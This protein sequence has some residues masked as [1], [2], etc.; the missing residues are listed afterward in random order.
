M[1]KRILLAYDGSMGGKLKRPLSALDPADLLRRGVLVEI[2]LSFMGIRIP[3]RYERVLFEYDYHLLKRWLET[4]FQLGACS[5][6]PRSVR[7]PTAPVLYA[8]QVD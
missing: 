4:L 8:R 6:R 1:Y 3:S 2:A 7:I 5:S